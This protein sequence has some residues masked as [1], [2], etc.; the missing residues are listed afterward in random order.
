MFTKKKK[1]NKKKK[2][3]GRRRGVYI[4]FFVVHTAVDPKGK[5]NKNLKK[6]SARVQR[7]SN[8]L[9]M[10]ATMCQHSDIKPDL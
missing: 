5:Q 2:Q 4:L 8:R 7:L 3:I 10:C 6:T 9:L 1:K